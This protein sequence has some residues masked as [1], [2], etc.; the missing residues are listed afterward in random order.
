MLF[1]FHPHKPLR[2]RGKKKTVGKALITGEGGTSAQSMSYC[3]M[4]D[5]TPG[6]RQPA[7]N[8]WVSC[9]CLG[10]FLAAAPCQLGDT[11][12][13]AWGMNILVSDSFDMFEP[14]CHRF[15][16]HVTTHTAA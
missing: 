10:A 16:C 15:S 6:L 14:A 7:E 1:F 9:C 13:S 8:T 5:D 12:D 11:Q 3:V 2:K 4:G